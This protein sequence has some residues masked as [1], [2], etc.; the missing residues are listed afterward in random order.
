MNSALYN[1]RVMHHRLVPLKHRFVYDVYMAY[2]D[3]DE[4]DGLSSRLRL[5]S[6][7]RFN[8]HE[9]RDTDHLVLGSSNVRE[10]I[11]LFLRTKGIEIGKG[12]IFLLTNL[13]TLGYVFNPVSFYF[14]FDE[15]GNPL[16]AVPEVGNTFKELKP[17][18]LKQDALSDK[19][20]RDRQIKY[21]YVSPYIDFDT[22][23]DFQLRIPDDRLQIK[24]DD[25]QGDTK[26]FI[27]TLTGVRKPLTDGVLL[28]SFL[29]IPFLTLKV[30]FLIHWHAMILYLKKL[31]FHRK[32]DNP[33]LQKEQYQWSK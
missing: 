33:E 25:F 10:N 23:F 17:F 12:K 30:I 3:L 4:I 21:F 26:I 31:P 11:K 2:L 29:R 6:R 16:C 22:E 18:V 7:N 24:I 28:W 32:T 1:C 15:E 27:S 14:C 8:L 20:F 13:R 5:F 9:F 19:V